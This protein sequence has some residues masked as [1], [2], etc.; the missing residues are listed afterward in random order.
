MIPAVATT[1]TDARR[2][3][4]ERLIDHAALFPPASMTMADALAEDARVR[5]GG[6][7]WLVGRFVVPASRLAELGDAALRLSVVLDGRFEGY[8]R[9]EAVELRHPGALTGLRDLAPEV[10]VEIPATALEELPFLDSLGLRAKV[11]CGG[12]SAPG[13][14]EL[15]RFVAA[16]RELGVVFKATA[17]LHHAVT[18]GGEH[19]FL[20]LLAAAVFGEEEE[21]LS[22]DDPAAFALEAAGFRWR[23]RAADAAEVARIRSSLFARF[24]SCSVAEPVGD[25]RALGLLPV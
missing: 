20:N 22:E 13:I 7:G 21:A 24:G 3:L 17:G 5:A 6:A 10:Y 1:V 19:G 14:G 2:A 12:E 4:L 23:D 11:R 18:S 9:V 16:C 15:A 25:L 8:P